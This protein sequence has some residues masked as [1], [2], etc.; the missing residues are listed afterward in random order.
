MGIPTV[1]DR[2]ASKHFF[3]HYIYIWTRCLKGWGVMNSGKQMTKN[4]LKKLKV[5]CRYSPSRFCT[6]RNPLCRVSQLYFRCHAV[7]FNWPSRS[8][9]TVQLGANNLLVEKQKRSRSFQNRFKSIHEN[10]KK[11][12]AQLV[13]LWTSRRA[14]VCYNFNI[15]ASLFNMKL[16]LLRSTNL[17]HHHREQTSTNQRDVPK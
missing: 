4:S 8:H 14:N 2:D 1:L 7:S 3:N 12:W 16:W 5:V 9:Y 13:V 10:I 11:Q 17:P 15:R 6:L